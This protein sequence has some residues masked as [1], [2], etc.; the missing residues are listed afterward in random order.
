MSLGHGDGLGR[1][2]P[3]SEIS[4]YFARRTKPSRISGSGDDRL[5][6]GATSNRTA[7]GV[8]SNPYAKGQRGSARSP[9][10]ALG[11]LNGETRYRR[12][13]QSM[14][15]RTGKRVVRGLRGL[16]R[17]SGRPRNL[18][19]Q[20]AR[21]PAC[22]SVRACCLRV[23]KQQRITDGYLRQRASHCA[24]CVLPMPKHGASRAGEVPPMRDLLRVGVQ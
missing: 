6:A 2:L 5:Y 20:T 11:E 10:E 3:A 14:S 4:I 13:T 1:L 12:F 15:A 19:K 23:N 17:P 16:A 8:G 9:I 21:R 18:L 22:G 7:I 24:R